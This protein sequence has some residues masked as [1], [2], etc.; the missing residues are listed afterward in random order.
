MKRA[1]RVIVPLLLTLVVLASIVWYF[2]VYDRAFTKEILLRSAR[3]FE[4]SG[5]QE[6]STMLYDL[7]YSQSSH[8][9]DVAIEL[10]QMYLDVG[11]YTKAEYT[12]SQA[13]TANPSVELYMELS[14]VYLMQ[15]KLMDAVS[16]LD[17][18]TNEEI[19][20][21]LLSLRPEAP[22]LTPEP[23]FYTKYIT[24]TATTPSGTLYINTNAEYPSVA[25]DAY[26]GPITLDAGETVLYA[27]TVGE[28]GLVSP[29]TVY[30]YT[31]GGV[32]EEVEF[33]DA[34]VEAKIREILSLTSR[35]VV[36]SNQL[37]AIKEFSVPADAKSFEDLKYLTYLTDLTIEKGAE[38]D[39]SVLT[40]LDRLEHLSLSDYK[41]DGDDIITIS[42]LTGLKYLS[43][44]NASLST[45]TPLENLT[46]LEYLDISNNSIRNISVIANM[47]NMQELYANNNVISDLSAVGSLKSLT[48]LNVS[49]NSIK[50]LEPLHTLSASL[51]E[52]H[53]SHNQLTTIK[54]ITN[55]LKL[56]VLNLSNNRI[57][58]I[59][60]IGMLTDLIELDLSNN[61][62]TDITGVEN[63]LQLQNLMLAHNQIAE[64]PAFQKTSRLVS[65]DISHNQVKLLDPLAGLP[66]LNN[67]NVDYNPE[68][69][70]LEPLD[71]CPLLVRVN[72]YGTLV[73]EVTFLTE[74]GVIVN[75]DPTLVKKDENKKS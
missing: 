10:S 73:T 20:H 51:T 28:N 45:I 19:R 54:G 50:T 22:V 14:K 43:A 37:W 4:N 44:S 65:I 69:E 56:N 72:A 11:N 48:K 30:G 1:L 68:L 2:L 70:S 16:L 62:V 29:I 31:I 8:D 57:N 55:L 26:I 17:A 21:Q 38:G 41:L 6:I 7:A 5:N 74:K 63:M 75:F 58:D 34:A 64:L 42:Q 71:S 49:Y 66:I 32:V 15:D 24:V 40:K 60:N 9:D 27:L 23:G 36:F 13:I 46:K 47:P 35:E 52:L 39:L 3:Y 53:A 61:A 12:L 18:V 33:V 67:V 25:T 59:S